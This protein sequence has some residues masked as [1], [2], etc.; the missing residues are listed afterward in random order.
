MEYGV[1]PNP[2]NE[3]GMYMEPAA[4]LIAFTFD[5]IRELDAISTIDAF[6]HVAVTM[7]SPASLEEA[8]PMLEGGWEKDG[9]NN[10]PSPD[11]AFCF[12]PR[13]F[14]AFITLMSL[15]PVGFSAQQGPLRVC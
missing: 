10:A 7:L 2:V 5:E 4:T 1:H 9:T 11:L 14:E 15:L 8:C 3:K 12:H 6:I 13:S